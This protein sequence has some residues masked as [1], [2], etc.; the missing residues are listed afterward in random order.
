MIS[1]THTHRG[2]MDQD[3]VLVQR[4]DQHRT[5]QSSTWKVNRTET[6]VGHMTAGSENKD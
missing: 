5:A 3:R 6:R 4:D 2:M 1:H